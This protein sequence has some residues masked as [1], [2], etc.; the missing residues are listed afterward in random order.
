MLE[1]ALGFIE[2][3]LP[4]GVKPSSG[5]GRLPN[6]TFS[7]RRDEQNL[8][9]K[10]EALRHLLVRRLATEVALTMSRT[11]FSLLQHNMKQ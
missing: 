2:A 1:V 7:F 3:L 8:Y 11:T 9:G 10:A 6:P 4:G 5:A